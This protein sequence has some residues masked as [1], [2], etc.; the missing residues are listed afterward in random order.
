M[1]KI[2]VLGGAKCQEFLI[3]AIAE[4]KMFTCID[5][6]STFDHFL[7]FSRILGGNA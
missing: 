2:S 7:P 5:F 1:W 3:I 6:F 4:V